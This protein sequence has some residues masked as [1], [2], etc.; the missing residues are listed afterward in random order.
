MRRAIWMALA[1]MGT[2]PLV[3]LAQQGAGAPTTQPPAASPSGTASI[4]RGQDTTG[5]GT[6][7]APGQQSAG[8]VGTATGEPAAGTGGAG[9]G[10]AGTGGMGTGGAGTQ[11]SG[12]ATGLDSVPL[13]RTGPQ[14]QQGLT[15]TGT[16]GAGAT[17]GGGGGGQ[18]A[19]QQA[20]VSSGPEAMQRELTLLRQRVARLESEVD[21]LRG[22]GGGGTG[23]A[24]DTGTTDTANIE[25]RG[26][27]A[28]AT[29]V[30]DG[31]VLNVTP[32]HID[33]VDTSDGAFYR[34]AI[35]DETRAFVG[36][37]LERIPVQK[38]SEGTPVRTSFAL[39]SGEEQ[40]LNIVTQPQQRQPRQQQGAPQGQPQRQAPGTQGQQQRAPGQ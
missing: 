5:T 19:V 35:N 10:G 9:T 34:L 2:A 4:E 8:S 24:G 6:A 11:G 1:F 27:V 13:Q 38:I 37:G 30:F 32:E 21:A 36:P 22:T 15:G 40:A 29:A 12:T 26:P 14:G 25:V 31:R 39:V 20:P 17:G 33:I 3:A 16:G 28:V 18:A 7:G 23:G